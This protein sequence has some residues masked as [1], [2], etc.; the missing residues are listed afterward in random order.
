[1]DQHLTLAELKRLLEM[2]KIRPAA[3]KFLTRIEQNI[4]RQ[5]R[6]ILMHWQAHMST[7]RCLF[8]IIMCKILDKEQVAKTQGLAIVQAILAPTL[9][10]DLFGYLDR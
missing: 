6:T 2:G 7:Y 8:I 3:D 1:M 9:G 10:E 4:K 5:Y